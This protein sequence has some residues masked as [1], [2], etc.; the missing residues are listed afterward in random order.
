M[1]RIKY[2]VEGNIIEV[3]GPDGR[4]AVA[5]QYIYN[6][7]NAFIILL[8]NAHGCTLDIEDGGAG[9]VKVK[10]DEWNMVV[11]GDWLIFPD[12]GGVAICGYIHFK[13]LY[14]ENNT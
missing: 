13:E 2:T 7:N 10:D 3:K 8:A 12:S 4:S 5:A 11:N 6:P 9:W 1:K 14:H